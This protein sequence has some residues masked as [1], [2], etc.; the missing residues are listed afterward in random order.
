MGG[1]CRSFGENAYICLAKTEDAMN[2]SAKRVVKISALAVGAL[3]VLLLG[4]I[5][6][7]VNFVFTPAKLTPVVLKV[8]N[9]TLDAHLEMKSVELTFFSTFPR[10]GLRLDDGTLVSKAVN[11]TLWTKTDSL[12][13]FKRCVVV[14]NPIDYLRHQK[15]TLHYV[16]LNGAS[17]YAYKNKEGVANWD[18][19][20]ADT[21]VAE[22]DT[23]ATDSAFA[24]REIDVNK[25]R[26]RKANI[27]FDDRETQLYANL[28]N[29]NLSLKAR[30]KK[31][32]SFANL[33]FD[34][35]NILLW[36]EGQLL[37]NK[38]A[39]KV[40][41][42][43]DWNRATQTLTLD[44]TRMLVNG[45]KFGLKG[46][47]RRDTVARAADV[48]LSY[49]LYA[50]SIKTVLEMVPESVLKKEKFD[51]EGKVALAGTLKGL[52][53]KRQMPVATLDLKV[54]EAA[55]K[56]AGSPYGVDRLD[57]DAYVYVDLMRQTPSYVDLKKFVFQG[58]HTDISADGKVQDLLGDPSIAFNTKA[59]V[60]LAALS[61]TFPLQDG[62]SMKGTLDADIRLRCLLSSLQQKDLGRIK[63]GGKVDMGQLEVA[64]A[65]HGF[66]F[67]GDALLRFFGNDNLGAK[68]EVNEMTLQ[69]G[70]IRSTVERL[71]ANVKS[72]NPQD[73]TKIANVACDFELNKLKVSLGDSIAL[74]CGATK[75]KATLS[76]V[77]GKYKVPKLALSLE[78]DTLFGRMD[79]MRAGMDKGG[80]GVTFEK[81]R[82]S[83]WVP[84]GII[85]FN[86]LFVS[87]PQFALPLRMSKTSVTVGNRAIKLKNATMRIGR[88]SVTASGAVYDLY[89][90]L[91][92][93][94]VLRATLD[95]YSPN[96][97]CNQLIR[98]MN[99][100]EDTLQAEADTVGTDQP[101]QLFV[102]PPKV[103][104][105]LQ[106]DLRRVVYGKMVFEDV[107][108]AVDMRNQAIHLKELSMKG[109]G[110][111]IN[112]TLVYRARRKARGYAGFDF[113]LHDVNIGKLVDFMPSLDSVVP[114]LRSFKGMVNF[115][116]AAE[117]VLDS[118]MNVKIPSLRAAVNIRGDSLVLM[119]GETFAEI[120][121]MLL[122]KNK[123]RNLFDSISVNLTVQDGDVTIYP[124]VVQIDRYK[125]AVG[126]TQGLDMNFDYHISILKSPVPF[127]L[128][129]NISGNLDKMK[130]RL[131]KAKYKDDVTPVAI[132]KVDTMRM[133]MGR[134][135]VRDFERVMRRGGGRSHSMSDM[136]LKY[137][138]E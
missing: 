112:A 73:T 31:G 124:F 38:V 129:L 44:G 19:V 102:L 62:I 95:I 113:K 9:Q 45:V 85:G 71:Q 20:K 67:T 13:S 65:G 56:Y 110:A 118:N 26:V 76:P 15:V 120:S 30:L 92:K 52:Y 115:E 137:G 35:E 108:G 55:V 40:E 42:G 68:M 47:L 2:K 11:D 88:S 53:G 136:E 1:K 101:M 37:L 5:A 121:K 14:V 74:F 70:S 130:F 117:A 24:I 126:G 107:K 72:T 125:A 116:A 103:D 133:N 87:V 105:E 57:A 123:E 104:F 109:L 6:L 41:T 111:D 75:A 69:A 3:A 64:D 86:R 25:I 50:P 127:K 78:A 99:F 49:G 63:V 135:I 119:D 66:R 82:D 43:L 91:K 58:M 96:L 97:N 7:A 48:D 22:T 83:L 132:Y 81:V 46:T 16:A 4:A 17:I 106:T 36:Q 8:A 21:T 89:G 54:K 138:M 100:P 94:K 33:A 134:N 80:F 32:H 12:L 128:G 27:V 29:A 131:G 114:M 93:G 10:F 23:A 60:D 59:A 34:N 18:I 39:M 90:A 51:A 84:K 77:E 79:S 61:Q 122:F 28:K 98:A